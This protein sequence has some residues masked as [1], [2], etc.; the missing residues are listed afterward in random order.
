MKILELFAGIGGVAEAIRGLPRWEIVEAIDIDQS[1]AAVY[2]AN[3]PGRYRIATLESMVD[4]PDADLWWLSPPCQPYTR[5]GRGSGA[6]DPRSA[7]LTH[8]IDQIADRR[9]PRVVL[10][11]VPEFEGSEHH[12]RLGDRLRAGGYHVETLITCPTNWGVPMRRRR[13]YL[14]ADR[15]SPTRTIQPPGLPKFPLDQFFDPAPDDAAL[16]AEEVATKYSDAIDR[17]MSGDPGAVTACFTSAY[18][19]SPVRSGSYLVDRFGRT[20]RFSPAEITALMGFRR[21]FDWGVAATRT[22]YRLIGNSVA[23]LVVGGILT[24]GFGHVG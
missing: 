15:L 19:R 9:P 24:K 14:W 4:L 18:G 20:R 6:E 1:A 23:V 17:V 21:D 11:N 13:F 7:A 10:E 22:R 8:L 2:R 16:A 12:R 3:H 5:R